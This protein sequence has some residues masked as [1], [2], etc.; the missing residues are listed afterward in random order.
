[1]DVNLMSHVYSSRAVLPNM[2]AR[3]SGYLLHTASAAGL[4]SQIGSASYAVTKHA[5]VAL[6]EW[7]SITH[8]DQG[9]RVS[10]L[11]PMGVFTDMLKSDAPSVQ[12]LH[13]NAISAEEAAEAVVVGIAE[14]KFLILPHAEVAT[15]IQHK[16]SD[17][18]RWLANMRQL[19]ANLK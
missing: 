18:D 5:A 16:A 4:L 15:F 8:H 2:I 17:Y 14:E 19:A 1:M 11:C 7:L 12:M 13:A 10:C 9:I 3:G 6:A